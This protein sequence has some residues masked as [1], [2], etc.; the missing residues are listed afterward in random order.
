MEVI[1]ES[2]EFKFIQEENEDGL[3]K[4]YCEHTRCATG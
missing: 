4:S 3:E 1:W 2:H